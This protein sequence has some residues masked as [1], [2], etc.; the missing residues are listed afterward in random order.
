LILYRH[1]DQRQ[2]LR[3]RPTAEPNLIMGC[4]CR[5]SVSGVT[6]YVPSRC[7]ADMTAGTRIVGVAASMIT[8]WSAKTCSVIRRRSVRLK[9]NITANSPRIECCK[10]FGSS[11][12]H[13]DRVLHG[14]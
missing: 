12:R 11:S 8:L 5:F 9:R 13:S 7:F 3:R 14:E 6:A 4:C 2:L 1:H 10:V